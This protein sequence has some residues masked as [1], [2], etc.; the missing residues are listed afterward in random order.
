MN[1]D[2]G[3]TAPTPTFGVPTPDAAGA[4]A[5]WSAAALP[6]GDDGVLQPVQCCPS[7]RR[8]APGRN[9]VHVWFADFGRDEADA[10]RFRSLLDPHERARADRL[11]VPR[12]HTR[13]VRAHGLL[14]LVLA[15]YAG[16]SP[17]NLRF[18]AGHHG[19]PALADRAGISFSLSGA[20]DAVAIAVAH[21]C[22]VGIDIEEATP[23]GDADE[24]VARYFSPRELAAYRSLPGDLRG[25][26]FPRLWTRKE[27][28][29][30]GIGRG[31]AYPLDAFSVGL[32]VPVEL[33]GRDTG[34]WSLRHVEPGPDFAA[35][36]AVRHEHPSLAGGWLQ[37]GAGTRVHAGF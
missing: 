5:G 10:G 7:R 13:F 3:A 8:A 1:H 25:T 36:L 27:A 4:T 37:F 16:D 12:L 21:G 23:V 26:A 9:E 2:R 6:I 14:R 11:A 15:A 29:V 24:L 18:T 34:S 20:G 31:L 28:F 33:H 22:E 17:A 30:K 35:A 19:K 32:G